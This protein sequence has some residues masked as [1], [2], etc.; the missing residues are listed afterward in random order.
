MH[1]ST[2]VTEGRNKVAGQEHDA[3]TTFT[4]PAVPSCSACPVLALVGH[5]H[6]SDDSSTNTLR[7]GGPSRRGLLSDTASETWLVV[8]DF[9]MRIEDFVVLFEASSSPA[10]VEVSQKG[11]RWRPCAQLGKKST[12]SRGLEPVSWV[13][14]PDRRGHRWDV[15]LYALF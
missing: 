6:A 8:N 1:P 2:K 9:G 10:G 15:P 14:E 7:P 5:C 4:I 3:C 11:C 12:V 13:H